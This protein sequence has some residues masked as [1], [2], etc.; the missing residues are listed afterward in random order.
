MPADAAAPTTLGDR[1]RGWLPV[2]VVAAVL[3]IAAVV[4]IPLGGWDEVELQSEVLPEQPIGQPYTGIRLSTAIDDIYLTDV[5]PGDWIEPEPGER[6][7]VVVAT[8][9]NL[10]DEP[11]Y[12]FESGFPPFTVPGLISFDEEPPTRDTS[13]IRDRDGT[14][15]TLLNPHVPDTFVFAY[16]VPAT[17]FSGGETVDIGITDA[18][19]AEKADLYSGTRW[20][21]AHVAVEVPMILRDEQ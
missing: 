4:A 17:L 12:P 13:T 11:T 9:E 18:V 3:G 5:D 10:T 21:G 19:R 6:I 15:G 20:V 16:R 8:I 7:L 14:S 1:L 2:I